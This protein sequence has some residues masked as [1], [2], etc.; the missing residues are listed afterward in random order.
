[1]NF[2]KQTFV[3][4][5]PNNTQKSSRAL[6][7]L[8]ATM[9][10]TSIIA[11]AGMVTNALAKTTTSLKG[12]RKGGVPCRDDKTVHSRGPET[13]YLEIGVT[14][15]IMFNEVTQLILRFWIIQAAS[16]DLAPDESVNITEPCSQ[17]VFAVIGSTLLTAGRDGP[18]RW[19]AKQHPQ[20]RY[21]RTEDFKPELQLDI[22]NVT[23]R[24]SVSVIA[25]T[26]SQDATANLK[27]VERY[28][29]PAA[30]SNGGC[31]SLAELS[32]KGK[33]ALFGDF[34]AFIA[35]VL[36]WVSQASTAIAL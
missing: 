24:C 28:F 11:T 18:L 4:R 16:V 30:Q 15:L 27:R 23:P 5:Q 6:Q 7:G 10:E 21:D 22:L 19:E 20:D 14:G 12:W 1:M 31:F 33:E 35:S 29:F 9:W 13:G 34:L 25:T 2:S 8:K 3:D 36:W 17:R 26:R 32:D